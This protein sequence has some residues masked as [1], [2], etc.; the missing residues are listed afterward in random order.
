MKRKS[1]DKKVKRI[2][3]SIAAARAL[4]PNTKANNKFLNAA[5]KMYV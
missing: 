4:Y 3:L 5:N 2:E 1:E